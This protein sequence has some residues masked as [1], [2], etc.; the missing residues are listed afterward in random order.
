LFEALN[1]FSMMVDDEETANALNE[2][3]TK[4]YNAC[5]DEV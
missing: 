4:L 2:I 5:K 3:E 1:E